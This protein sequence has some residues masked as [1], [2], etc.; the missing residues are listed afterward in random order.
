V[1]SDAEGIRAH[2]QRTPRLDLNKRPPSSN[3]GNA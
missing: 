1:G 3:L 2:L